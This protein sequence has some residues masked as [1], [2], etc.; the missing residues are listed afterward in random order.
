[1]CCWVGEDFLH[2]G[3]VVGDVVR[4]EFGIHGAFVVALAELQ[5]PGEVLVV[6]TPSGG[7]P[8]AELR[9]LRWPTV[10]PYSFTEIETLD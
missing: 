1:M 5:G 4:V 10:S 8:S 6:G 7:C 3:G 9:S 2:E